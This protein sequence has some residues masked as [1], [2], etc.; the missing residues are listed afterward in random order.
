MSDGSF[1]AVTYNVVEPSGVAIEQE[2]GTNVFHVNGLPSVGFIGRAYITPADVSFDYIE[3]REEAV[4]AVAIGYFGYQ[5]GLV[6]AQGAWLPIGAVVVGKGSKDDSVDTIQGASDGHTPYVS[7]T[8]TWDIPWSFRVGGG[9][10]R[11]LRSY[12]T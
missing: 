4:N 1:V 9:Q 5:N 6:H 7:G 12:P 8:F 3:V 2:V 11:C 10:G